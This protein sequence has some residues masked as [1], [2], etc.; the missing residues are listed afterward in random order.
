MSI[1]ILES[2]AAARP[3]VAT[4][5]LPNA[6]LIE[7]ERTGL[8]VDPRAPSQ[9]AQAIARF[10]LEPELARECGEAARQSA[11]DRYTIERMFQET[12]DLYQVLLY[13]EK[14]KVHKYRHDAGKRAEREVT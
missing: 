10:I 7:H 2:M 14:H 4:S 13:G 1:S 6:E 5:I 8:L 11:L 9:I 3:I 12:W